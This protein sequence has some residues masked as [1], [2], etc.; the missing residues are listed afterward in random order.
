MEVEGAFIRFGG[1]H[2]VFAETADRDDD[3]ALLISAKLTNLTDETRLFQS[4]NLTVNG[5]RV[6]NQS[7][8]AYSLAPRETTVMDHYIPV[9][10][11][12]GL[13]EIREI[14]CSVSSRPRE[15]PKA[16]LSNP[17]P[18][19]FPVEPLD[20]SA[21]VPAIPEPLARGEND[22]VSVQLLELSEDET[23]LLTLQLRFTGR[24][25][26]GYAFRQP[27]VLLDGFVFKEESRVYGNLP[28][29]S[30]GQDYIFK[31]TSKNQAAVPKMYVDAIREDTGI[32]GENTDYVLEDHALERRGLGAVS[33]IRL[34][35]KADADRRTFEDIVLRPESPV[36]LTDIPAVPD[37]GRLR[38]LASP[39]EVL[40]NEVLI[41]EN[42][43][44]LSLDMI[45]GT[46]RTIYLYAES[47]FVNGEAC[48]SHLQGTDP[49]YILPARTRTTEFLMLKRDP[50]TSLQKAGDLIQDFT[51]VWDADRFGESAEHSMPVTVTLLREAPLGVKE[52]LILTGND[53]GLDV[54]KAELLLKENPAMAAETA[55]PV[56]LIPALDEKRTEAFVSGTAVV[57]LRNE[58]AYWGLTDKENADGYYEHRT[59]LQPLC[60]TQLARGT[61][62]GIMSKYSGLACVNSRGQALMIQ[63]YSDLNER[64]SA[65]SWKPPGKAVHPPRSRRSS[66]IPISA[67]TPS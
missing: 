20:I 26:E 17:V 38:I 18:L 51:V 62:G 1:D 31:R 4:T 32:S 11:L 27:A 59:L 23:G 24:N 54:S 58:G 57:C 10:Q 22:A 40:I 5:T 2:Y 13:T 50:E 67:G 6:T 7:W 28:I 65:P 53:L 30:A 47:P 44:Y 43:V 14:S 52:G 45:N 42:N 37:D 8:F 46:D 9:S 29:L 55:S 21:L 36:P 60:M 12:Q 15:D 64:C 39:A 16:S 66:P 41:W 61:D 56:R 19:S 63:E 25:P 48:G 49:L 34:I 3:S 33:E 35:E